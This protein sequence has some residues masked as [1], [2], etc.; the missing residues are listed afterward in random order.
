MQ[1]WIDLVSSGKARYT[2]HIVN[3]KPGQLIGER[4]GPRSCHATRSCTIYMMPAVPK[5]GVCFSDTSVDGYS[6]LDGEI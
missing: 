4:G 3:V 5:F 6:S 2:R 1:I